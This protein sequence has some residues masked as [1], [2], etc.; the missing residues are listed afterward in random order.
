MTADLLD[1][2]CLIN[3][4]QNLAL[5]D[6]IRLERVCCRW[7]NI[8]QMNACYSNVTELNV[9]D[10]LST[11]SSN[12]YQQESLSFAPTVVGI[13]RRCGCYVHSI[14]FGQRWQ[15]I[16]Q[17]IIDTIAA[18]CVRLRDLD[19]SCVILNADISP[20]LENV[21][22]N[23][24]I[25]SLEET[26]WVRNEDGDEVQKYFHR[27]NKLRKLN[28]RRAMF[29]LDR[30]YELP[31][32][33]ESIE[34]SG[35]RKFPPELFNEFLVTHP[36]IRQLGL[37]PLPV[38]NALTLEYISN[39]PVL[40]DLQLGYIQNDS[41]D[42][43]MQSLSMCV[44]LHSLHIQSCS[45]LTAHS[46]HVML[47]AMI[48][49]QSLIII[50]CSNVIDYSALSLCCRLESLTI[51][52]TIQLS[53]EDLVAV[54]AH[55]SLHSLTIRRCINITN[56]SILAVLRNCILSEI[57]LVNCEGIS[58]ETM[59]SLAASQN[60]ISTIAVQG[61]CGVTSKGVAALALLKHILNLRELDVSHNRNIDDMAILSIHNGLEMKRRQK[62]M[63]ARKETETN[64]AKCCT[65]GTTNTTPKLTIY[66]FKTSV[67][68]LVEERVKDLIIITN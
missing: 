68:S 15:K 37:C 28:V 17:P 25:F 30:L 36:N 1:T 35:A 64:I 2:D 40:D 13:I 58:D 51:A 7:F 53:D 47:E 63:K 42:F 32:C 39:L 66:V 6:R 52:D 21:A 27:M 43:P 18:Y 62:A 24:E 8:L 22:G 19:L 23:L 31:S 34:M 26:S 50:N 56:T 4:F 67:S 44:S 46:L 10:F 45:A 38:W 11:N 16:S 59:Y 61:C 5:F 49:L 14:S 33:L 9:A 20:L 65:K 57:T 41:F 48:N 12:Y 60:V 29:N 3:V 54:A 55:G